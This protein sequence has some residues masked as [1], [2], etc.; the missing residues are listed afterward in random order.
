[1]GK[2]SEQLVKIAPR[3]AQRQACYC[4]ARIAAIVVGAAFLVSSISHVMYPYCFLSSI[5]EYELVGRNMGIAIATVLPFLQL[6]TAVCLLGQ[7]CVGGAFI[8]STVMLSVF[9]LGQCYALYHNYNISCGC[10][11]PGHVA[12]IGGASI[13]T[14]A[15]L[16]IITLTGFLCWVVIADRQRVIENT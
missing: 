7:V 12:S 2:K 4:W 13:F 3:T 5:Y 1:M 10:W 8:M 16:L 9:T 15:F 6:L 14:V 11:G